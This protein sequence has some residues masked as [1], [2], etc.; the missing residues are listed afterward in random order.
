MGTSSSDES[1]SS[2]LSDDDMSGFS[3]CSSRSSR[4]L[5]SLATFRKLCWL[6]RRVSARN[7]FSWKDNLT[8]G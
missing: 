5:L 6:V 8:M 1:V 3:Y 4:K 7:S 2:L